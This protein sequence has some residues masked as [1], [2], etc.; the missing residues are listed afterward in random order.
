MIRYKQ[1]GPITAEALEREDPA[2]GARAAEVMKTL[3]VLLALIALVLLPGVSRRPR[4][5]RTTRALAAARASGLS[6]ELRCLV[7]QNQ[8]IAD[9]NAP[10]AE[11]LRRQIREQITRPARATREIIDF[12]VARY[13]DF[14]LYRP[15]VKATTW[16]LWFGPLAFLLV[17]VF[18]L[19]RT[20]KTRRARVDDR[21]L[22]EAE[23]AE[24]QRLLESV[25][26]KNAS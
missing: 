24:A 18:A 4:R 9:S 20:L 2:A 14:V 23:H 12:M 17:A 8:T 13:G 1:I 16:L 25:H 3:R 22:T 19:F 6:E 5:R 15:P 21:P 11:D 10:L 26:N 7:C